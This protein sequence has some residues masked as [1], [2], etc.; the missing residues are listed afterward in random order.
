MSNRVPYTIYVHVLEIRDLQAQKSSS[1]LADPYV[2]VSCA[3]RAQ[4][5]EIVRQQVSVYWDRLF[6]FSDVGLTHDEFERENIHIQVFNANVVFRN[7]LLGQYSYGIKKVWSQ[8]DPFQHQIST[9]WVVLID[10]ES[11]E[12]EQGYLLATV[13]VL[14]PGDQPPAVNSRNYAEEPEVLRAPTQIGQSRRGYNLLF[15]IFRGENILKVQRDGCDGFISVKFNGVSMKTGPDFGTI[16]P[17]WN[18]LLTFPVYTPCLTD[19]ID[20]QLWDYEAHGPDQLLATASLQFSYIL[21]NN[22]TPTWLNLYKVPADE[23]PWFGSNPQVSKVQQ[24]EYAG[25]ILMGVSAVITEQPERSEKAIK[26]IQPPQSC[27]YV[28]HVDVYHSSVL[29]GVG[30]FFS[31]ENV[32]VEMVYGPHKFRSET[33]RRKTSKDGLSL[34]GY[35]FKV[36]ADQADDHESSEYGKCRF[37]TV[38]TQLPRVS[39]KDS[40]MMWNQLYDL[41]LNVYDGDSNRIGF[42]RFDSRS[43]IRKTDTQ[44]LSKPEWHPLR[45]LEE[46]GAFR[47]R[48]FLLFHCALRQLKRGEEPPV[49]PVMELPDMVKHHARAHVYMAKDLIAANANG[50][51]SPFVRVSLGGT[52]LSLLA[53]HRIDRSKPE[54]RHIKLCEEGNVNAASSLKPLL[55]Q[56]QTSTVQ[57]TLNPV[58]MQTLYAEVYLPKI[59]GGDSSTSLSLAPDIVLTVYNEGQMGEEYLGRCTY[60]P[61]LCEAGKWQGPNNS[62][63][64]PKWFQLCQDDLTYTKE[65]LVLKGDREIR[66]SRCSTEGKILVMYEI[67]DED[68]MDISEDEIDGGHEWPE[69]QSV[70]IQLIS[71]GL[72][73]LVRAGGYPATNPS[74]ELIVPNFPDRRKERTIRLEN[75]ESDRQTESDEED[76][77]GLA[78]SS[79]DDDEQGISDSDTSGLDS[80]DQEDRLIKARLERHSDHLLGTKMVWRSSDLRDSGRLPSNASPFHYE[81]IVLDVKGPRDPYYCGSMTVIVKDSGIFG[82]EIIAT[83]DIPL[84]PYAVEQMYNSTSKARAKAN[85]E[86]QVKQF[87]HMEKLFGGE[88]DEEDELGNTTNVGKENIGDGVY[89]LESIQPEIKLDAEDINMV[90]EQEVTSYKIDGDDFDESSDEDDGKED[91]VFW[92]GDFDDTS[93][94]LGRQIFP[95]ALEAARLLNPV[96]DTWELYYVGNNSA[97]SSRRTGTEKHVMGKLKGILKMWNLSEAHY[98]DEAGT[99]RAHA[100]LPETPGWFNCLESKLHGKKRDPENLWISDLKM[101]ASK[102]ERL[103]VRIYII[104]ASHLAPLATGNSSNPYI[105]VEMHDR[106]IADCIFGIDG[107]G[108]YKFSDENNY[109]PNTLNPDFNWWHELDAIL[110][111]VCT[112]EV[113][114]FDRGYV[115]D[116]M[117]G[118]TYVDLEDR[119]FD[120]DWRRLRDI[121]QVPKEHRVLL[122]DYSLVS[123]GKMEMWVEMYEPKKAIDVPLVSIESPQVTEWELRLVVWETRKVPKVSDKRSTNMYVSGELLYFDMDGV[124]A[125]KQVFETDV[126]EGVRDGSGKFNWRMKYRIPIPCKTPRLR[127]QVH[128]YEMFGIDTFICDCVINLN[129]ILKEAMHSGEEVSKPKSYF[130]LSSSNFAGDSRGEIDLQINILPEKVFTKSPVGMAR[131]KPND[132]PFLPEPSRKIRSFFNSNFMKWVRRVVLLGAI[133][134]IIFFSTLGSQVNNS[135]Q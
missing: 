86:V 32:K 94:N 41:I 48:G 128:D 101:N 71:L 29:T 27:E 75:N 92:P 5:T 76:D 102:V 11:P 79:S 83:R 110:P 40:D 95:V 107:E 3:G 4:R 115:T 106:T 44:M 47:T 14:G 7:E 108:H 33:G 119:W 100:V 28:L 122:N 97:A 117:I 129:H 88:D 91:A 132:D 84:M 16:S 109:K 13:T 23:L 20:I 67:M 96:Y 126:H 131:D 17:D 1:G 49:R 99:P 72:R 55:S 63:R 52:H 65:N 19:N 135:N 70:R 62:E 18:Q 104:K 121:Q 58:W 112:L 68:K 15:R 111:S 8:P 85:T 31:W 59:T 57:N 105:S 116:T 120:R 73:N 118:R 60:P 98:L 64:E 42:C 78:V 134:A 22:I 53:P 56:Q 10:P 25:R 130:R 2:L 69:L 54:L 127:I 77:H 34:L 80:D 35:E 124:P 43:L 24:T 90:F 123:Q 82:D 50:L 12:V 36:A 21:S 26:P 89:S 6:V 103:K 37:K 45:G 87:W 9:R 66:P 61:I 51:S 113:C 38:R 46:D 125:P 81:D 93:E 133:I 114:L 74:F 30:G 39:E